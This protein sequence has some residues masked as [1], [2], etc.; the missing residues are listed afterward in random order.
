MIPVCKKLR[1]DG[2]I[3]NEKRCM[4]CYKGKARKTEKTAQERQRK[5]LMIIKGKR[6]IQWGMYRKMDINRQ[7]KGKSGRDCHKG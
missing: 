5:S 1:G 2:G 7:W 3:K 6:A 4:D